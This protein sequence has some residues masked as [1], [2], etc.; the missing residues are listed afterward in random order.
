M[1]RRVRH[2]AA[3]AA[4]LRAQAFRA[5]ATPAEVDAIMARARTVIP[6]AAPRPL[7]GAGDDAA[8]DHVP[9]IQGGFFLPDGDLVAVPSD[10]KRPEVRR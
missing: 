5:S 2:F 9:R 10:F 3:G 4:A 1:S 7:P 8:L 6:S